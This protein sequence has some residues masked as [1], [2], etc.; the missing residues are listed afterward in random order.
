VALVAQ[1]AREARMKIA[2]VWASV[3]AA[4]AVAC[5]GSEGGGGA[6]SDQS[7][8]GGA[9]GARSGSGG[10]GLVTS[11]GGSS[12]ASSGATSPEAFCREVIARVV[13]FAVRCDGAPQAIWERVFGATPDCAHA[14]E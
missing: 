8:N 4:V 1:S 10:A 13:G 6:R 12:G 3:F 2:W 14:A 5:G 9:G 7:G 11:V